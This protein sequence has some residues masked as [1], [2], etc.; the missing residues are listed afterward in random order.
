MSS[1]SNSTLSTMRRREWG[2]PQGGQPSGPPGPPGPPP[3]PSNTQAG[4]G[5]PGF[6][7]PQGFPP[8]WQQGYAPRP[9]QPPPYQP[10]YPPQGQPPSGAWPGRG[11]PPA[12]NPSTGGMP[13]PAAAASAAP[14]S[15]R[16][17]PPDRDGQGVGRKR[18]ADRALPNPS[19]RGRNAD[20]NLIPGS[21]VV[22]INKALVDAGKQGNVQVRASAP[23]VSPIGELRMASC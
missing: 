11:Q 7:A 17:L 3:L 18:Q 14:V 12:P 22:R 1:D 13:T 9:H 2:P 8:P 15:W 6:N 5:H 16:R 10:G 4:Y 23:T 20:G 21:D 19:Q